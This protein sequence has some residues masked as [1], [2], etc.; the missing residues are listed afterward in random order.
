MSRKPKLRPSAEN[1]LARVTIGITGKARAN[2]VPRPVRIEGPSATGFILIEKLGCFVLGKR[3]GPCRGS[4]S[5]TSWS[6]APS[7]SV[8]VMAASLCGYNKR[9]LPGEGLVGR[10]NNTPRLGDW[11]WRVRGRLNYTGLGEATGPRDP[12][13]RDNLIK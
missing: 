4:V 2:F 1:D 11:E 10:K 8:E 7:F 3:Q 12:G 9:R 13:A 5:S 6:L